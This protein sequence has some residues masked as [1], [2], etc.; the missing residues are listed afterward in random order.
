MAH[1]AKIRDG[2]VVDVIVAAAE[3]FDTF[4]D[5]SAG[6]WLTTS[7]NTHGGVHAFGGTPWRKNFAGIGYS[8]D[9]VLDA[10]IPP[11]PIGG[12][13]VLDNITCLW[14]VAPDIGEPI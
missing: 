6:E 13:W 14:A 5:T 7:Y 3:F 8:Y 11:K 12:A 4:I 1:F 2:I 9:R 10:F